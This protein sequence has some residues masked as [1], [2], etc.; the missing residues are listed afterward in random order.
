MDER[1]KNQRLVELYYD[2]AHTHFD[3]RVF[4]ERAAKLLRST[5]AAAS[6]LA[7]ITP[8]DA[9]AAMVAEEDV[10]IVT[11][12]VTFPGA[13]GPV[14]AYLARPQDNA[15]HGAVEVIHAIGGISPHIEDL[16]RRFA[17]AGYVA[18]SVDFLSP[19]GGTPVPRD[20]EVAKLTNSLKP[21]ETTANAVAGVKYLRS[22]PEVNG[23]VGAIG[24]C[25][26]GGVIN[27]LAVHDPSLNAAAV[28]YGRP[29]VAADVAK[30]KARMLLNYAD[31]NLDKGLGMLFP[32]YAEELKQAGAKYDL[33]VYPGAN[34]A[35]FDDTG[36]RHDPA[37][38]KLAWGRVLA[39]F[40]ETLT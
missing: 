30:I 5:A 27:Q 21:D 28:F 23:K 3:R 32:T 11:E 20:P 14:K 22:R 38:A 18:L 37:A 10:R 7:L 24:F 29:P 33:H 39:T 31:P 1:I 12:R 35:F 15:K 8:N 34:H 4:L 16:A 2:Y 9:A 17:V 6:A 40:K 36:A 26:G 13:T 19:L 25:W